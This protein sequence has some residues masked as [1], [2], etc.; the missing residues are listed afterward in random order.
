[1]QELIT[2]PKG[3]AQSGA[4]VP[5]S[6]PVAVDTFG[7][8]IHVDWNLDAAVTPLGQ[9]P[10]FIEFLYVSGLFEDWVSQCPLTWTSPNAPSKR[11]V[12]GTVLSVLSGLSAMRI[13][14]P[15]AATA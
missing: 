1:M 3:E 12:L 5:V 2:H 13:S 11:D 7:G 15:C 9:L 10:F 14:T 6:V 8:R 4:L